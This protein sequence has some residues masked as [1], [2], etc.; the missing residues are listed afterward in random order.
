[1][2]WR[3][4]SNVS[5]LLL[6]AISA[7]A[8][9]TSKERIAVG[10]QTRS[11]VLHVPASGLSSGRAPLLV[12]LHG[13]GR[14]GTSLVRPWRK[15]AKSE[16]VILAAPNSLDSAT[17]MAPVDGPEFIVRVAEAVAERYPVDRRRIYLF[18]HSSGAVFALLVSCWESE[19]FAA[20]SVHAGAFRQPAEAVVVE[21]ARRKIPVQLIVGTRDPF[22]PVRIVRINRD[23][24][25]KNGFPVELIEIPGHDHDY[26][27]ISSKVNRRAWRFLKDKQLPRAPKSKFADRRGASLSP[28]VR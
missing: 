19:Y 3:F 17:W 4:F 2:K 11:Y 1:M 18:G 6:L 24:F 25:S 28:G 21:R 9:S 12:L 26:Y 7:R 23:Y 8:D 27:R 5:L 15:L 10:G 16:G 13:S 14:D 20:V 22:F